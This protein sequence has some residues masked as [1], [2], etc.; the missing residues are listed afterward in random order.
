MTVPAPYHR[1]GLYNAVS[2]HRVG[3]W[4]LQRRIPI[5]PRLVEALIFFLFNSSIPLSVR[6]GKGTFCSHRGIAVVIHKSAT[7][8]S[9]CVIGTSVV[10]GGRHESAP[11]GPTI[12]DGVYIG[13]GAKIIGP[14]RV[15]DG[16]KIG[17]NAVVL[18]DVPEGASAVGVP[19]KII[20]RP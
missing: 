7:I 5:L 3:V 15:G 18:T 14:V 6:I 17:A 10:L 1:G 8:G 12:G 20:V 11:G 2:F 9:D 16:A 19:A 13:T 4:L